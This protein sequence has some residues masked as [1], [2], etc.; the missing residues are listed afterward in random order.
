MLFFLF[1]EPAPVYAKPFEQQTLGDLQN[2]LAS[3]NTKKAE[4]EAQKEETKKQ[5]Q[6]KKCD[7]SKPKRYR[8][9]RKDIEEAEEKIVCIK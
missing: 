5:I 3:L 1:C 6:A 7:S 8:P 9:S 4:N 2:E